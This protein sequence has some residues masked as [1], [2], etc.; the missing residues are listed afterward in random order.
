VDI[1]E[2]SGLSRSAFIS[3]VYYV[4]QIIK[5]RFHK[6][7]IET[8]FAVTNSLSGPLPETMQI[9]HEVIKMIEEEVGVPL[10]EWTEM[11]A[12]T[13]AK[14]LADKVR[15]RLS[16][17][18]ESDR[19]RGEEL[20]KELREGYIVG[21][22]VVDTGKQL[23]E[24]KLKQVA[25]SETMNGIRG[26]VVSSLQGQNIETGEC[27]DYVLG[28]LARMRECMDKEQGFIKLGFQPPN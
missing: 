22:K 12:D 13:Y 18:P 7:R 17:D 24:K 16:E 21:G 4:L 1:E 23:L 11:Q 15:K 19:E 9:A 25:D 3:V 14:I 20:L 2:L 10:T 8:R 26:I 6:L 27:A 28:L 5:E